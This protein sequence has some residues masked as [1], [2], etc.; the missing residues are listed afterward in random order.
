MIDLIV[1]TFMIL[2]IVAV[3]VPTLLFA[4]TGMMHM[5]YGAYRL[6]TPDLT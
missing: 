6:V 4:V 5:A 1:N 2:G 3:S